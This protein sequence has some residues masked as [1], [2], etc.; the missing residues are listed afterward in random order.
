MNKPIDFEGV[1]TKIKAAKRVLLTTHM[2]P[3]GDAVGSLLALNSLVSRLGVQTRMICNDPVPTYLHFLPGWQPISL[4]EA[5][6][7]ESF[8]LAISIDAADW[9]RLGRSGKAFNQVPVTIQL[10]HHQTN[11]RFAMYNLV[12][13]EVPASGCLMGMLFKQAGLPFTRDEAIWL[14]TAMSTDTGNFSFSNVTA[15]TFELAAQ[16]MRAGLPLVETARELHLMKE[17]AHVLLLGKAL[18]TLRFVHDGQLSSMYLSKQD[19][20]DSGAS[21]EHTDR[22]VNYG[23]YIPGVKMAYLASETDEGIKF[24]LR[25]LAPVEVGQIAA[26]LGGG[27]H[28]QAAGCTINLPLKEAMALVEQHML[29]ALRQ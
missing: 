4:P 3:D 16:L 28:A 24:S 1:L 20:A 18:N 7:G 23:L 13:D 14:Y 27:G 10:D 26:A 15:H 12:L 25:A 11:S 22:I 2:L 29:E 8:D 17:K 6:E 9:E 21:S 19:Y 5:V